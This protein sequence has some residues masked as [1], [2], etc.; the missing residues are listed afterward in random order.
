M[1]T[2][3]ARSDAVPLRDE[4]LLRQKAYVVLGARDDT[5]ADLA[6]EIAARFR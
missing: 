5:L 1:H 3:M 6:E 2:R 4:V